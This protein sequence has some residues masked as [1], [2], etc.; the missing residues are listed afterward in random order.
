MTTATL[1]L[2]LIASPAAN[3]PE[4]PVILDF[5]ASWCGPCQQMKPAVELLKKNGYPV[6][7]VDYDSSKALVQKYRITGVPTF[8]V[9]DADGREL[10]RLDGFRPAKDIADLYRSANARVRAAAKDDGG[11]DDVDPDA[12]TPPGA[13]PV[14]AETPSE[15]DSS[16]RRPYPWETTVRIKIDNPY[17]R[18]ASVEFGSGTVI[19]SSPEETIILTCA[20]IFRVGKGSAQPRPDKFNLPI[21]VQLFDGILHGTEPARVHYKGESYRGQAIDYDFVGDVGLIRIRPGKRLKVSP[22]VPADWVPR[23]KTRMTTVGSSAGRDA[24]AWTTWITKTRVSGLV[25]Y[26]NYEATEC[27]YAPIPG[28]SGGG[29]YTIDGMVAGVCDFAEPTGGHGLYASPRTIHK[30]LD[31][32]KLTVCYAPDSARPREGSGSGTLVAQQSRGSATKLRAQSGPDMTPKPKKL[33]I[34]SPEQLNVP[35]LSDTDRMARSPRR[36]SP[37]SAGGTAV[38]ATN[39]RVKQVAIP[40]EADDEDDRPMATDMTMLPSIDTEAISALPEAA[41]AVVEKPEA[42]TKPTAPGTPRSPKVWKAK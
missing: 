29:L 1:F 39:A 11:D 6:R 23:E 30:L 12:A 22:V 15:E 20:H 42:A 10:G 25:E 9:V 16:G 31:R 27:A 32:N 13:A 37:W 21:E 4:A 36:P 41:P 24:T 5:T 28:R 40:R 17:S 19:Y 34:P 35:P 26:P 38:A 7:A 33:T 18:P 8:V 3:A 2:A 14:R